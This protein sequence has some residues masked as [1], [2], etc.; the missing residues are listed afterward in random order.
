MSE[1]PSPPGPV[2]MT[3]R[4]LAAALGLR[5][6]HTAAARAR[7]ARWP[8][9]IRN[10][11]TEAEIAVPADVL[12]QAQQR[13]KDRRPPS[14][15]RP[16]DRDLRA[17]VGVA[18]APL[19]ATIQSLLTDLQKARETIDGLRAEAASH[20]AD[21]AERRGAAAAKDA[22]IADLKAALEREVQD[23]RALRLQIE[24]TRQELRAAE[25]RVVKAKAQT[26]DGERERDQLQQEIARL[27]RELI[28][29]ES[30]Q[31]RRRWWWPR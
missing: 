4:K 17:A 6:P 30:A 24:R 13:P 23:H 31:K 11:T 20:Q 21:V 14:D 5:S 10:D 25:E 26:L 1:T 8:K 16:A 27:K 9:R 15:K 18:V 12:A 2:W 22:Q 7:R 28:V 29:A 19:Q 3:Y